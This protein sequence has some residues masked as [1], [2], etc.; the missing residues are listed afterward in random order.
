MP[1]SIGKRLK[2][3]QL[4]SIDISLVMETKSIVCPN[5]LIEDVLIKLGN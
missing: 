4:T 1:L 5:G 2:L 3:G